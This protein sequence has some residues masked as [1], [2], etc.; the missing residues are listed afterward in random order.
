M[1]MTTPSRG[2]SGPFLTR[3]DRPANSQ[4]QFSFSHGFPPN[5]REDTTF[6]RGHGPWEWE[7]ETDCS[8]RYTT[9]PSMNPS[10]SAGGNEYEAEIHQLRTDFQAIQQ[11]LKQLKE[12]VETSEKTKGSKKVPAELSV[13]I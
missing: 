11:E 3:S 5:S 6:P 10:Y 13:S 2:S 8:N 1:N 4:D 12:Q 7:N 9:T